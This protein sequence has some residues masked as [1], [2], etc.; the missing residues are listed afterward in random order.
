MK[1]I[2]L[3]T[4]L[5]VS[6][7]SFSLTADEKAMKGTAFGDPKIDSYVFCSANKLQRLVD[8]MNAVK[9]VNPNFKI[10][11]DWSKAEYADFTGLKLSVL[12]VNESQ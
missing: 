12:L 7:Y 8:C 9:R 10:D 11:W 3:L 1:K 6:S 2:Y 4:L 5:I